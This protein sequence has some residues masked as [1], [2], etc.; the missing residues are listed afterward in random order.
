MTECQIQEYER[1]RPDS[2]ML[3]EWIFTRFKEVKRREMEDRMRMETE[4]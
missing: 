4:V 1:E 3:N 2:V